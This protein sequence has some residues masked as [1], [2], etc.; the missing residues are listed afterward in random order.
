MNNKITFPE[1]IEAISNAT[2]TSKRVSETFLKELFNVI[3]GT[4]QSG[5]NVKIKNLGTFKVVEV[6][7]RKSIN[8]N[9]GAE[10]EIPAHKKVSFLPDK[11]IAE[12]INMPFE[13]FETII[14]DDNLSEDDIKKLTFTDVDDSIIS[15][16]PED[17]KGE[18]KNDVED[19][20]ESAQEKVGDIIDTEK[21]KIVV[22]PPPFNPNKIDV[23]EKIEEEIIPD[24]ETTSE[25]Q[26]EETIE[27]ENISNPVDDVADAKE[28]APESQ[29]LAENNKSNDSDGEYDYYD[30]EEESNHKSFG[31]G[32]LWGSLT[33]IA[34]CALVAYLV[35]ALYIS[36]KM[37]S[38]QVVQNSVIGNSLIVDSDTTK[39]IKKAQKDSLKKD[40]ISEKE[41]LEAKKEPAK[42]VTEVVS[43]KN[44]LA[45][46]ALRHYG[47]AVFWVYI[48]E[49]NKA[50]ISNPN[51]VS[52]GLVMV[53]P[54]AE[55]YGIDKTN[56]ASVDKA[57]AKAYQILKKF[58]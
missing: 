19:V 54:P 42:I 51:N 5:E 50:K 57:Q 14:L 52:P 36:P 44:Y 56:K 40:T 45:Q 8:V 55:K 2:N 30:D 15:E 53:I 25:I 17:V 32:F 35:Y 39:A 3:S 1:L 24:V 49:E 23:S 11:S 22:V 4:L 12:A 6:D 9:T 37:D 13:G 38:P 21:E 7:A 29:E 33:G 31:K 43:S 34:V 27:E 46:M 20:E 18:I 41:K 26:A 47:K 10:M 48:Y 58:E 16:S 28:P